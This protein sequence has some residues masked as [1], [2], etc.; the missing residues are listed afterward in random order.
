[1]RWMTVGRVLRHHQTVVLCTSPECILQGDAITQKSYIYRT[2]ETADTRL[3]RSRRLVS[4]GVGYYADMPLDIPRYPSGGVTTCR[5]CRPILWPIGRYMLGMLHTKNPIGP[6][7]VAD[8]RARRTGRPK[9]NRE[10]SSHFGALAK[11][12]TREGGV[13]DV[14]VSTGSRVSDTRAVS[15]PARGSSGLCGAL[16]VYF[17][18]PSG[19]PPWAWPSAADA[20]ASTLECLPQG[21]TRCPSAPRRQTHPPLS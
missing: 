8:R 3:P 16:L 2:G 4:R 19:S 10:R 18:F 17:W 15:G 5:P 11:I 9:P 13:I 12:V 14:L 7:T 20:R 1:M 6:A 21:G